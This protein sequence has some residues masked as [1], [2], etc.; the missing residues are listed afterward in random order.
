MET[1]P[2][3]PVAIVTGA[4]QGIGRA[5]AWEMARQGWAVAIADLDLSR[6]ESVAAEL[7]GRALIQ[8]ML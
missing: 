4:A 2:A 5:T 1:N 7:R 3:K 8:F 6:A